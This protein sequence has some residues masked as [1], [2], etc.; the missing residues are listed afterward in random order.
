MIHYVGIHLNSAASLSKKTGPPHRH[1]PCPPYRRLGPRVRA[2]VGSRDRS[3][4]GTCTA[5]LHLNVRSIP[6]TDW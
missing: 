4:L 5:S 3:P 2:P 6:L 1:R